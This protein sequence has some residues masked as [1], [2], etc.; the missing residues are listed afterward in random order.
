MLNIKEKIKSDLKSILEE[1]TNQ[2]FEIQLE[3]PANKEHGDYATNVAMIAFAK[4]SRGEKWKSPMEMAKKIV[5]EYTKKYDSL[6]LLDIE[7]VEIIAPGFINFKLSKKLLIRELDQLLKSDRFDF[8]ISS[9]I[10]K[11]KKYIVEYAHPNT[12]KEMHIGHMRTLITGEALARILEAIGTKVF[13]ANYQG[14]IGPHVAKAIYGVLKLLKEEKLS[15]EEIEK[16]SH[17][18]KAHFLGRAYIIGNQDYE[19]Y[20]QEIDDI[21]SKLYSHDQVV[22]PIYQITRK[23]SLDYFDELYKRFYTKFDRLFFESEVADCG[24]KIVLENV[25]KIFEKDQGA[26]VFKGEKFGL[27]TRVFVTNQG[28]PTYEG[29]EMCLGF[30]EYEAF[31]FDKI[32]HVVGSEQAGYFKVVFKALELIDSQKFKDTQFHLSMGMVN[33]VGMKISSRTGEILRVDELIDKVKR[34]VE[35]LIMKGEIAVKDKDLVS[36][37]VAIGA[38]KYSV[39][40]AGVLQNVDFDINK[41]ISLDGNSGPYIQYTYARTRS[42]LAKSAFGETQ[43][44]TGFFS[45]A[46][47]DKKIEIEEENLLRLIHEFP[48]VVVEA[49]EKLSP[50]IICNYLFGIAQSFNLFYQKHPILKGENSEFRL[51]LT[52]G[53]SRILKE[54][55]RL[56]G[57]EAPERM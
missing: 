13:R 25:G 48:E 3:H 17:E 32:I 28:Y 31:P 43:D 4:A 44:L 27:H 49:G 50:S 37:Q 42:V 40:K 24:K 5:E 23:W 39:L 10:N 21:N 41:S 57:I 18:D 34:S 2:E 22:E 19:S 55:L 53:V 46:Q 8:T 56:L 54:G 33:I 45:N 35:S 7:K 20:K 9:S 15:L 29:K 6:I 1:I 11:A 51:A 16:W 47:N 14:D 38:I 26:V 12:H 30:K 52:L 36:E